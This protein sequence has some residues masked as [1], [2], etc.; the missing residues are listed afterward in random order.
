M[1]TKISFGWIKKGQSKPIE[2]TASRT[3]I[4]LIGALELAEISKPIVASYTTV[5][6]ESI[7]DFLQQIRK[8]SKIQVSGYGR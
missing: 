6:A 2:T 3:R 8:Y 7:V 4:N 1:A 5:H